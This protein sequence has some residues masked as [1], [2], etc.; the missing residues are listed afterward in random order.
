MSL[1]SGSTFRLKLD[2]PKCHYD[3][4]CP[5]TLNTDWDTIN[6]LS[7]EQT[8][9][10]LIDRMLKWI[11]EEQKS[12]IWWSKKFVFVQFPG[13]EHGYSYS[14]TTK[15]YDFD[16]NAYSIRHKDDPFFRMFLDLSWVCQRILSKELERKSSVVVLP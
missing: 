3:E 2:N 9:Q 7:E 16:K 11:H 15:D 4:K 5:W 12:A 13:N 8:Y 10:H 1:L 6:I 14:R